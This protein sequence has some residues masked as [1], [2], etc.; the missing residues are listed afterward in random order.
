MPETADARRR[1]IVAI[2]VPE[3]ETA[4]SLCA[5]LKGHV[6][7]FKIGLGLVPIGGVELARDLAADGF[8]VFLDMKLFDIH[9]T[10]H[11][12]TA[13]IA[14]MGVEILTLQ[15]DPHVVRAAVAGR[16]SSGRTD[17]K[18][19]PITV[20]TSLDQSDIA[21]IGFAEPL[22]DLALRRARAS[23]EAGADGVI[24]SGHEAARIK[25][26]TPAGF[27]VIT[28]GIRPAG[29]GTQDQKRVMT[30]A[31]A[32]AAGADRLVI[33]RPITA[34]ADPAAA[35]DAICAEIAEALRAPAD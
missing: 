14:D 13:R 33:G 1:L 32:I 20:L 12:A 29:S 26:A 19:F 15:G 16:A 31:R 10:V 3:I 11:E 21:E 6:G 8:G 24:A 7:T 9:Q 22:A 2:D 27:E 17:L 35:A 34:A 5:R 18:L 30:P 28:P 4:R 23:A 25:A